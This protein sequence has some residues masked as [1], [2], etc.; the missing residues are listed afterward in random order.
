MRVIIE[1]GKREN[2]ISG[3][4][5]VIHILQCFTWTINA[6]FYLFL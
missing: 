6:L 4:H 2:I 5:K 3:C 1:E